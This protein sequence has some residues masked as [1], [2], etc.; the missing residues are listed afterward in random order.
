MSNW[1][2]REGESLDR[3]SCQLP[4]KCLVYFLS[5]TDLRRF[6]GIDAMR[7]MAFGLS[8]IIVLA[9]GCASVETVR[10]APQS[11]G[12]E[13]TFEATYARM[14]E[15]VDETLVAL[16]LENVERQSSDPGSPKQTVFLGTAGVDL[17]SWGEIVRVTVAEVDPTKTSVMVFWRHRLRDGL[18]SF[19]PNWTENLFEGIEERLP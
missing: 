1:H 16:E 12:E 7:H 5:S 13:Q 6:L 19:A 9:A 18:I 11:K 3:H 8:L 2:V 15:V 17:W 10:E 14:L 4:K